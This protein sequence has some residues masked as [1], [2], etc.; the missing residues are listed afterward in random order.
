ME[1][2]LSQKEFDVEFR[3]AVHKRYPKQIASGKIRETKT[4]W[5][6]LRFI[7]KTEKQHFGEVGV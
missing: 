6:G 7:K 3:K 2:I 5:I 1:K 4:G